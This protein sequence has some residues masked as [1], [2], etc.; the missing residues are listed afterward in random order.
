MPKNSQHYPDAVDRLTA[1]LHRR[2]LIVTVIWPVIGFLAGGLSGL[3]L[4]GN[5]TAA[6]GAVAGVMAG[7]LIGSMRSLYY[8][9]Q[10]QH[11]VCL[12][13][14]EENTRPSS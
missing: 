10:A 13:Q 9:V 4:G 6:I 8:H 3:E 5:V 14:I 2:A 12:K 7:C 1:R 11:L